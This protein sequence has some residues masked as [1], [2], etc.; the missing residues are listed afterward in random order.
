[1]IKLSCLPCKALYRLFFPSLRHEYQ[2]SLDRDRSNVISVH[3][4]VLKFF[5]KV[6]TKARVHRSVAIAIDLKMGAKQEKESSRAF[7]E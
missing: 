3:F 5:N 7:R 1:M 6:S 2:N 4:G